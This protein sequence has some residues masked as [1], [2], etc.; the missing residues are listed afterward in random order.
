MCSCCFFY[1]FMKKSVGFLAL[2]LMVAGCASKQEQPKQDNSDVKVVKSAVE[3]NE[4]NNALKEFNK[5]ASN[6]EFYFDFD[7]SN[8]KDQKLVKNY[9]AKINNLEK[10]SLNISGYCDNKG[11][12]EY[13][14]ALGMRRAVAVKEALVANGMNK[15]VDVKLVSFGES[16][17]TKYVSD[18]TLNDS[19]NR[20]VVIV[21]E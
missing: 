6:N 14:N 16:K 20:K 9:V 21:A 12:S 4:V 1:Y 10:A 17:Y 19:K 5:F 7:K 15:N 2:S 11:S 8:V 13:N 3:G 18:I